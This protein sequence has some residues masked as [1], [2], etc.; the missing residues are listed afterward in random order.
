MRYAAIGQDSKTRREV[1][2]LSLG[3][4]LIM[5]GRKAALPAG[6]GS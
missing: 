5:W 6:S 3:G 1:S 2:V 4:G